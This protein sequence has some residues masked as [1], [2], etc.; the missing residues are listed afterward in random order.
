MKK[1]KT[2]IY[3]LVVLVGLV[4]ANVISSK[5]YGRYDLTKDK[6]Y[7]LSDATNSI[8][9]NIDSPLVID[10]FLEGE[11]PSEF[12][13]LQ[14]E[15]KQIIEEFQLK[16]NNIKVN[17]INPIEDESTREQIIDELTRSGLEPYINTDNSTGKVTQEIIF[18]WAFPHS[19]AAPAVSSAG[20]PAPSSYSLCWRACVKIS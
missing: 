5:L 19:S 9:N 12:R 4:I 16:T 14:T 1:N 7:T 18:P 2:L 10:V 6:R 20:A 11:F 15:T 13:L 8:I 3:I 17:Y